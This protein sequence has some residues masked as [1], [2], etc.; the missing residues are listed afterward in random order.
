MVVGYGVD[1]G[2]MLPLDLPGGILTG[3]VS[4]ILGPS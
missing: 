1:E 2:D 3:L 4:S